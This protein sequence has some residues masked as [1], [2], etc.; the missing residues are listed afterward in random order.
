MGG[1]LAPFASYEFTGSFF[2]RTDPDYFRLERG[3]LE[4]QPYECK[5]GA[6]DR[7]YRLLFES[8]G[9]VLG[10]AIRRIAPCGGSDHGSRMAHAK[11]ARPRIDLRRSEVSSRFRNRGATIRQCL[12]QSAAHLY[13]AIMEDVAFASMRNIDVMQSRGCRLDRMVTAAGRA[14]TRLWHC[15]MIFF[16]AASNFGIGLKVRISVD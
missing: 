8:G 2:Y 10:E 14:K 15:L 16:G 1:T 11:T 9:P 5:R 6:I 7:V 13:R 12:G 3:I 4:H